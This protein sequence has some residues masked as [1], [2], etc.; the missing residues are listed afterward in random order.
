MTARTSFATT[1]LVLLA[2]GC[3]KE[4]PVDDG[5]RACF[6]WKDDVN[7]QVQDRCTRCHSGDKP[8]GNYDTSTYFSVLKDKTGTAVAIAG[9]EM[10]PLFTALGTAT[11]VPVSD[12]TPTLRNWVV[13]CKVAYTKTPVH[14]HGIADPDSA[15]FHGKLVV[16]I[17]YN[18]GF[19]AKCHGSDFAGGTANAPCTACHKKGPTDC[20]TCHG[21]PPETGA[22]VAHV[23]GTS[24]LAKAFDCTEC[25]TKPALY[26]DVGHI[27]AA[28]GSLVKL[29]PETNI[30]KFGATADKSYAGVT[31]GGP[32]TWDHDAG[33]C[34]NVYCHGGAF[35]ADTNAVD[36][37]PKWKGG[38]TEAACGACHGLPPSSHKIGD[39]TICHSKVVAPGQMQ[40]T[41][42]IIDNSRHLDGNVSLGDESGQCWAC[43]GSPNNP[44]P[45]RDLHGSSDPAS[46][47][48]GA[49]TVHLTAPHGLRGPVACG[50]C[51]LVPKNVG[52]PGHLDSALPAEV[53]P[54]TIAAGSLAFSD[55]AK[56]VWD[57]TAASGKGTCANVYCHGGGTKLGTDQSPNTKHTPVWL[58]GSTEAQC[59]ACHGAPPVNAEHM[60]GAMF[61]GIAFQSGLQHCADCH[62]KS[63]DGN[64]NII[65]TGAPGMQTSTHI[66]GVVDGN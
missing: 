27:F 53:F 1:A 62:G 57:R 16:E 9:D 37:T 41:W 2:F 61:M 38:P 24:V 15:D 44:A 3:S 60:P 63:I 33:T 17:N 42:N 48:V 10:S 55:G 4:R 28:D 32:A 59:G 5:V 36:I 11:H 26:T 7:A 23:K 64:G 46:V 51:H 14:P 12:L 56:P 58:G 65:V 21:E 47:T 31:R 18:L 19:C 54:Q 35:A 66:N 52:D 30:V 43:H 13:D 29:P 39:C 45:P 20:G 49:H 25:H 50:D 34:S 22:H 8:A 40:G 6:T